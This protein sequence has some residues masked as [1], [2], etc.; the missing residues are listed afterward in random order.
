MAKRAS[1]PTP[2]PKRPAK[3]TAP[4]SGK[5][6]RQEKEEGE[7]WTLP[8]GN[9]ARLRP[10]SLMHLIRSGQIPD[11]LTPLAAS[12][13]WEEMEPDKLT[14]TVEMAKNAADLAELICEASFVDPVIVEEPEEDNEV[15]HE[16]IDDMDKAWVMNTMIQA[17]EVLRKFRQ[18]Q[19]ELMAAVSDGDED[20]SEA[21]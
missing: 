9:V 5:A 1:R 21:E 19:E 10:V 6:W 12:M 7:L 13:V 18:Q 8:S 17:A 3:P 4:T 16:H 11:I 15:S 20:G 14:G 2:Q